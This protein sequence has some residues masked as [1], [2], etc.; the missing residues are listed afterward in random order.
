MIEIFVAFL[1]ANNNR[2]FRQ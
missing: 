1:P 2:S